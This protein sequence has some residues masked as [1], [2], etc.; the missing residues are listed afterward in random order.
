MDVYFYHMISTAKYYKDWQDSRFPGHLLYGLT[1]FS[2]YG[3]NTICHTIPF[4]PYKWRLRLSFYNLKAILFCKKSFDAIYAVTH[5]GLELLIFLRALGVYKKPIIIWHHTA[6]VTPSNIFRRIYSRLFYK[7]IDKA[8]FFSQ[9]LLDKS[10]VSGKIK[11]ENA[12]L[13][14][15]GPDIVFYDTLRS[16]S[17]KEKRYISTGRERRDFITLI[18]AFNATS[19]LC[20]LF[21][22][23]GNIGDLNYKL[24]LSQERL[25]INTNVRVFFVEMDYFDAAKTAK[26]AFAIV[27][28]CL[29]APYTVGLTS[30]VEAMALGL[31]VITTDNPMYPIDVEKENIGIKVP[32]GDV[33]AWTKA[34][35]YLSAHLDEAGKMGSNARLLAENQY[36]LELFTKEVAS[37]LLS[38]K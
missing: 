13:I 12:F 8:C 25:K 9:V 28:S 24:I 27:I 14:H 36:N 33:N 30:L 26:N 15:W 38:T 5:N 17:D 22:P 2:K 18:K 21:L 35:Q 31:P 3:I 37:I 29:E 11:K 6:I 16:Q 32:Y 19:D 7:G 34:I 4:N 20:D 10:I 23:P 1:H